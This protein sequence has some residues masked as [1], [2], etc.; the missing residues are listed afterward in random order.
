M[1]VYES[2]LVPILEKNKVTSTLSISR[3]I[4]DR[5]RDEEALKRYSENLKDLVDERTKQLQQAA[6]LATL[7]EMATMVG[8]DLRNPLQV[9]ISMVYLAKEMLTSAETPQVEGQLS[10]T[11]ILDDI[12]KSCSYM[13]QIISDLQNYAGPLNLE[14]VET[15]IHQLISNAISFLEIPEGVEVSTE[16][17]NGLPEITIDPEKIKRVIVNLVNNSIQSMPKGGQI[18]ITAIRKGESVVLTI[19]DEGAG[20]PNENIPKTI[21]TSIHHQV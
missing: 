16:V 11:E 1:R 9:V 6:R 19:R 12:E 2:Y 7:G 5:K 8:H 10:V 4:T 14:L 21:F 17:E 13:N 3:D 15:D 18:T 20:I